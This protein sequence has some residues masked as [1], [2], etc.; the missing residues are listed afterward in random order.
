MAKY[1]KG[2]LK[3]QLEDATKLKQKYKLPLIVK[4]TDHCVQPIL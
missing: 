1:F 2:I 3:A 4:V